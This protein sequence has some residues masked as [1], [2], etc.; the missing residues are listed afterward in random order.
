VRL[1]GEKFNQ[2]RRADWRILSKLDIACSRASA[3]GHGCA[4]LQPLKPVGCKTVWR[5]E[6]Q[7]CHIIKDLSE[8][9]GAG[10]LF[11]SNLF[12]RPVKSQSRCLA[13]DW[14]YSNAAITRLVERLRKTFFSE[15]GPSTRLFWCLPFTLIRQGHPGVS[16]SESGTGLGV[17]QASRPITPGDRG[18]LWGNR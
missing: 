1:G 7:E 12:Q 2:E 3:E 11:N 18:K 5:R 16:V 4:W 6:L 10:K 8:E 17:T 13:A 9:G 14:R 15:H